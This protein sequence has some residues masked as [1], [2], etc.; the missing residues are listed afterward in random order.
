[1]LIGA[2]GYKWFSVLS[3]L[4]PWLIIVMLFFTFCKVN[5]H[6]MRLQRWHGLL[7]IFQLVVSV[8][9]F[10]ALRPLNLV[11]AQGLMI[12]ILMPTATAAAVIT[13]K[14]GGSIESLT[15]YTMVSNLAV[16]L[17]VPAFFPLV[18]PAGHLT[19]IAGFLTILSKVFPLLIGPFFA[20][21]LLRIIYTRTTQKAFTL[22][23]VLAA[24]PFYVWAFSLII[25]M[26]NTVHSLVYDSYD[27]WA[28]IGLAIGALAV[29]LLQFGIGK[30]VGQRYGMRISAGQALGQ[31]NTILGIW[32]AHTYLTPVSALGPAAY[33]LWQNIFNSWQLWKH[34]HASSDK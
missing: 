14:L 9:I 30:C 17:F 16:A 8:A 15:T 18:H 27:A 32:M 25:L 12:C 3:P 23:P 29:C 21:W 22:H 4:T 7:L 26:A 28:A 13:G 2:I 11:L 10:Y 20:A 19:F 31:K 34:E 33:I 24:S 5:P 6:D 1:M